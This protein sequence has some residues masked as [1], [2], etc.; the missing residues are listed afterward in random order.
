M[1]VLVFKPYLLL[2]KE[3]PTLLEA[4]L[5]KVQIRIIEQFPPYGGGEP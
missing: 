3:W 2:G 4:T 1:C 5:F